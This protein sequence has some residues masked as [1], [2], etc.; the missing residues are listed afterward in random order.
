MELCAGDITKRKWILWNVT[1]ADAKSWYRYNIK[2]RFAWLE[3]L[4]GLLGGGED[5]TPKQCRS[6]MTCSMCR[7]NCRQR[8]T[9]AELH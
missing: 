4:N 6:S 8:I 2:K 1:L 9:E 3:V 7:K 5:E